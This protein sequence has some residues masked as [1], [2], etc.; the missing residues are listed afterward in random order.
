M[1]EDIRREGPGAAT[2]VRVPVV[3]AESPSGHTLEP[4]WKR[5]P[6]GP[7]HILY[8][9]LVG[10]ALFPILMGAAGHH[11]ADDMPDDETHPFFPDHF[12]PYPIIAVM[13]LVT[14]GLLAAFVQ[15]NLQLETSADPR[16]VTI[17]R[18]DWYFLFLFQFLK[19]GPEL[20]MS[21]VI[22]PIVV[23]GLLLWPF[24][25]SI[26]GPK[27]ARRLGWRTWPVPGRN[28]ITGT[29]WVVGLSIVALLTIWALA[30]PQFCLPWIIN[31][32]VCGA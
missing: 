31:S 30:G 18:P 32:P 23:V 6:V 17:P 3:E 27:M 10:L 11:L 24:I 9:V 2:A 22:P 7:D 19:L 29:L 14:V 4:E 13:M 25:D 28:I 1:S 20:I 16:T 12:W 26:A 5:L 8:P 15:R 21:L